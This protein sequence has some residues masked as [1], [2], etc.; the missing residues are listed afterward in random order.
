MEGYCEIMALCIQVND[1]G[2]MNFENLI[3]NKGECLGFYA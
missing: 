3:I 2:A 1:E